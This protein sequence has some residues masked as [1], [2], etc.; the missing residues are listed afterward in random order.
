M[1]RSPS[2]SL[3]GTGPTVGQAGGLGQAE[4]QVGAL[5]RLTRRALDEVVE[6]GEGDDPAGALVGV[7]GDVRDV[8]AEGGLGRR[9]LVADDD[10]RLVVVDARAAR[11]GPSSV[12]T[13]TGR[14]GVAGGEDASVHRRQMG[15]EQDLSRRAGHRGEVLLDLRGVAVV[16]Q[17]VGGEVLVDRAEAGGRPSAAGRR[18]TRR[19]PRRR[20]CRSARSGPL[21]AAA[22]GPASAAVTQQPG[23]AT[24]RAP[25][26][27]SRNSSG[28]PYTASA[29]SPAPCAGG[30]TTAD[31]APRHEAGSR[32]R[33]RRRARTPRRAGPA[34]SACDAPWGRAQKTRS[35]PSASA[36]VPALELRA[37]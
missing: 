24:S 22:P 8:R 1:V 31:T 16:E 12:V 7:R 35:R 13:R 9:W 29:N 25:A 34:R 37:P 20:R 33:D 17:A 4:G 3:T 18:P 21:A 28:R 27:S 11:R 14:T 30:R 5:D 23:A 15:R 19:S 6:R 36:V 10:E 2:G 26:S 32:R